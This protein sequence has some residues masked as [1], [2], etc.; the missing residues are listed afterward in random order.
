MATVQPVPRPRTV[1]DFE[2]IRPLMVDTLGRPLRSSFCTVCGCSHF[3]VEPHVSEIPCPRC[4]STGIRCQRPSGHDADSWHIERFEE[5]DRISDERAAA[6]IAV[7]APWP[8][9]APTLFDVDPPEG[10]FP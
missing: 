8:D 1:A 2:K 6:G 5:L 7:V 3:T 9:P 10:D 4:K